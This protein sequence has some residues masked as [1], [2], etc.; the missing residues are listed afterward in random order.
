[1]S[2]SLPDKR[3]LH[4]EFETWLDETMGVQS[5]WVPERNCYRDY[6]A[7]LAW[8]AWLES[9]RRCQIESTDRRLMIEAH[10]FLTA[11]AYTP[12]EIDDFAK[13]LNDYLGIPNDY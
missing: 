2:D 5:V 13:R 10:R 7:H 11:Q 6:Q 1:M 9:R 4:A 12:E 8:K 3:S